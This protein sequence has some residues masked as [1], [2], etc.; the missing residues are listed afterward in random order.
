MGEID[1][2]HDPVGGAGKQHQDLVLA[3]RQ[4]VIGDQLGA[5]LASEGGMGA[6]QAA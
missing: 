5:E 6:N 3:E 2:P 4:P 1:A